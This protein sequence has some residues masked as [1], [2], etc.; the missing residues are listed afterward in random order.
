MNSVNLCRI[1]ITSSTSFRDGGDMGSLGTLFSSLLPCSSVSTG[2]GRYL[3]T[4]SLTDNGRH[5]L[6]AISLSQSTSP[7]A[8]RFSVAKS[9][10]ASRS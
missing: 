4:V 8:F 5:S 2:C 6:F 10:L 1:S 7:S 3:L 9:G